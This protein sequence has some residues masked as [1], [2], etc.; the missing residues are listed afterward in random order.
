MSE[1][2][3]VES[4]LSSVRAGEAVESLLNVGKSDGNSLK[5]TG[6]FVTRGVAGSERVG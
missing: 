4:V 6:R 3:G 5:S 1:C 2:E